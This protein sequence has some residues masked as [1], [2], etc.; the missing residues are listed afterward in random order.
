MAS[1]PK[2]VR[3]ARKEFAAKVAEKQPHLSKKE[4]SQKSKMSGAGHKFNE[5]GH[6]TSGKPKKK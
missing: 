4:V 5:M 6:K 3:K 1:T 2:P